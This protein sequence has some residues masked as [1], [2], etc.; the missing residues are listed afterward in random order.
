MKAFNRKGQ[1][2]KTI[3]KAETDGNSVVGLA[4]DYSTLWGVP[5]TAPVL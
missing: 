5:G 1:C 4:Q 2:V 3:F